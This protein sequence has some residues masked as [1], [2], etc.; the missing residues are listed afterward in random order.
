MVIVSELLPGMS[1]KNYLNSIRPSQL[2]TRTAISYALDIA[3]AM[4]CLHA[5]SI[6]HRDLKPGKGVIPCSAHFYLF[7]SLTR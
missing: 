6:I 1:L 5:N 4:E 3:H 7:L 2:D